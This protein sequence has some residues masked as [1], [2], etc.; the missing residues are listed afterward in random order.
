MQKRV[1]RLWGIHPVGRGVWPYAVEGPKRW[2]SSDNG[3]R[4][5]SSSASAMRCKNFKKVVPQGDSK[6]RLV[7]QEC[8]FIN[9]VN[10][11]I[12]AGVVALSST[13]VFFQH[14]IIYLFI[15]FL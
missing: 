8:G 11:K 4:A 15:Y 1:G 13:C 6:E 2:W 3:V 10:P 9:Y 12:V 14:F 5:G 7:C